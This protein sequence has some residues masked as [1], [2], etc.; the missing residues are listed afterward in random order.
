MLVQQSDSSSNDAKFINVL[1]SI[2]SNENIKR[3][4]PYAIVIRAKT[5]PSKIVDDVYLIYTDSFYTN[6]LPVVT[7]IA[8]E[9]LISVFPNPATEFI[10]IQSLTAMDDVELLSSTGQRVEICISNPMIDV[11][12]IPNGLYFL[13]IQSAGSKSVYRV[14]KK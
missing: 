10:E 8:N 3:K 7:S 2:T 13:I 1:A 6:L 14:V 9:K 12:N 5:G 11:R 4:T